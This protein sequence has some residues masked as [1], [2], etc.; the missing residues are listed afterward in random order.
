MAQSDDLDT[1][2]HTFKKGL[3]ILL[4]PK[5]KKWIRICPIEECKHFYNNDILNDLYLSCV[6][7]KN[8]VSSY[9]SSCT[10]R[11]GSVNDDNAV[12]D[13]RLRVRKVSSLRV[14]DASVMP[15]IISGNTMA[16]TIMIGEKGSDMIKEDY[17]FI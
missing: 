16:P 10:C 2:R 6:I 15:Q 11:M 12:T 14:I 13:E 8:L 17:K 3:Q 5:F 4:H 9:H 7:K 1:L